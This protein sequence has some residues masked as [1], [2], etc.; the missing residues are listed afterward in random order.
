MSE[1]LRVFEDLKAVRIVETEREIGWWVI[2]RYQRKN[3]EFACVFV[4]L[5][6]FSIGAY[7]HI[8]ESTGKETSGWRDFED[9]SERQHN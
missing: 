2:R 1:D 9:K 3:C 4:N 7:E 5:C 8:Y 6:V